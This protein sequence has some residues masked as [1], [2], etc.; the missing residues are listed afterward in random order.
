MNDYSDLLNKIL[1]ADCRML[2][3]VMPDMN[4]DSIRHLD[5]ILK[6]FTPFNIVDLTRLDVRFYSEWRL[7]EHHI[8]TESCWNKVM[9]AVSNL[10]QLNIDKRE[11]MHVHRTSGDFDIS[12]HD[13]IHDCH[14][15]YHDLNTG[16]NMYGSSE[17]LRA[18][19][20]VDRYTT[21]YHRIFR[22]SHRVCHIRNSECD[23]GKL[24]LVTDSMLIP[25]V[26]ILANCFS[27]ILHIDNRSNITFNRV[28]S[29]YR[30]QYFVSSHQITG[31]LERQFYRK[32]NYA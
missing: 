15:E 28:L 7:N 17:I 24:L 8:T 27:E 12:Y 6:S 30:P 14:F 3:L 1:P 11:F 22:G 26:P 18:F 9:P 23:R 13:P 5:C 16:E 4:H 32:L 31:Y 2:H 21:D 29:E 25:L 10:L 20:C 19:D